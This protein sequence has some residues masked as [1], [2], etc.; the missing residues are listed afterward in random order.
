MYFLSHFAEANFV[1][2]YVFKRCCEYSIIYCPATHNKMQV[3]NGMISHITAT[4]HIQSQGEA[5]Q[6]HINQFFASSLTPD[7]SS[8][9]I[10][11]SD[12]EVNFYLIAPCVSC[13]LQIDQL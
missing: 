9:W 8:F 3:N 7:S 13:P 12:Q 5:L 10:I 4:Y 1:S 2:W 11:I 6:I